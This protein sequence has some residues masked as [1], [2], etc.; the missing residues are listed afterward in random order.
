MTLLIEQCHK[1]IIIVY[2]TQNTIVLNWNYIG[3]EFSSFVL[4]TTDA[5]LATSKHLM[6]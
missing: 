4:I 1:D 5:I 2:C 3:M 6:M